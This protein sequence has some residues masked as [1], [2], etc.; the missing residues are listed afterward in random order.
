MSLK[1][2]KNRIDQINARYETFLTEISEKDFQKSPASGGWSYSEV[3]SHIL[4]ANLLSLLALEK[5]VKGKAEENTKKTHLA[6]W[7]IL[8]LGKFPPGKIKAPERIAALVQK[9]NP[10]EAETLMLK[11]KTKLNELA[12]LVAGASATQ[13]AKHP[14]LGFLNARQWLR[15]IQIHSRHHE[16][17][18]G[19]IQAALGQ[20]P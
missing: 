16:K 2:I 12:P 19:R 5:C 9:I 18:L 15:F 6:V 14:R 10:A 7:L 1:K 20:K 4:E 3:Y 11:F 8:F 17:Q 13:K